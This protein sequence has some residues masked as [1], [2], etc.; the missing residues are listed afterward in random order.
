MC[1]YV[2][3]RVVVVGSNTGHA[4][5]QLLPDAGPQAGQR[6][7]VYGFYPKI[8]W[9]FL[10]GGPGDIKSD[11]DSGWRWKKCVY[12]SR[13][14]YDKAAARV[15]DDL[16]NTPEY[17]LLK[18]NCVD[19]AFRIAGA[20]GVPLPTANVPLTNVLDPER[21]ANSFRDEFAQ[22]GGRNIPG[23]NGVFSN[24]NN[25]KPTNAVDAPKIRFWTDSYG[26]LSRDARA[27]PRVLAR[28][29]EMTAHVRSLPSMTLGLRKRL[30]VSLQIPGHHQ[31]LTKVWF[32]DGTQA[33]QRRTFLHTYRRPGTYRAAGVVIANTTVYKFS[34]R[35]TVARRHGRAATIVHVP[36]DKPNIHAVP[37]LPPRPPTP[38]P[39]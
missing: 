31:A 6:D 9:R 30:R 33:L 14:K 36:R 23:G 3:D 34:F 15:A 22:Q 25:V 5:V 24:S 8:K 28:K 10:I 21:L 11:A 19:W 35:V 27:A 12:V 38:E 7:L 26:D 37:P 16:K 32:G 1:F 13:E 2:E 4:F 39:E 18:F 20:A 29:L 17:A